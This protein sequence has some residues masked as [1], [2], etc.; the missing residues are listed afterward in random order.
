MENNNHKQQVPIQ[1]QPINNQPTVNPVNQTSPVVNNEPVETKK[2]VTKKIGNEGIS[3]EALA[4]IISQSVSQAMVAQ[5]NYAHQ[6]QEEKERERLLEQQEKYMDKRGLASQT[7]R[8]QMENEIKEGR[9][10]EFVYF[11]SMAKKFGKKTTLNISGYKMDFLVGTKTRVPNVLLPHVTLKFEGLSIGNGSINPIEVRE[12][13][14]SS[15]ILGDATIQAQSVMNDMLRD[16]K[17]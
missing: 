10:T 5:Q 1:N 15:A 13:H 11:S 6:L 8:E 7:F 3:T 17:K 4:Q 16:Y 9:Y 2:Q 14:S 12:N